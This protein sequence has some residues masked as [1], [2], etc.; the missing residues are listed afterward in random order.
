MAITKTDFYKQSLNQFMPNRVRG[1]LLDWGLSGEVIEVQIDETQTDLLYAGDPVK[2]VST[3][4]GK[5]KVV[6]GAV[7]DKF[8]GYI[9]FNPKHETF[10]AGDIVS[11]LLRGAV[12]NCVTEEALDA[13]SIVYYAEDGSVTATAPAGAQSRVGVVFEAT[14]A[15]EGGVF[16]PVYVA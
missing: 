15:T 13:G 6:A 1:E 11:I 3:S 16:V 7:T 5:L 14:A 2:I 10:K 4:K 9:I 8:V 12:M